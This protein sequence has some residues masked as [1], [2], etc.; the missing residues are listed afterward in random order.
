[1][2]K[3]LPDISVW[4]TWSTCSIALLPIV[5]NAINS[6][7]MMVWAALVVLSFFIRR[8]QME[9][10]ERRSAPRAFFLMGGNFVLLTISLLYSIDKKEG[11]DF[12][13]RELS[14][15]LFPLCFFIFTP[16]FKDSAC[17]LQKTLSF[18]WLATV[19]MTLWVFFQYW[20]LDLFSQFAR[21]DSFNL[22]LRQTAEDLTDKHADYLSIYLVFSQ[23]IAAIR[24]LK[25]TA[26]LKRIIYALSIPLQGLL[27]FLLAARSPIIALVIGTLIICFL[28]IGRLA[29][30]WSVL[31]G[32]TVCFLAIIRLT[33]SIW[34]R[35]EEVRNTPL[36]T[37]VGVYHNSTNIRV[38]I[39]KCT[40]EL[41]REH[42]LAGIGV[43]SD[44]QMLS[45]CYAQFPTD[46]Y[47]KTFY[48][49][50][51]QYLNFWLLGGILSLLLFLASIVWQYRL[52]I[53][54]KDYTFLFFLLLITICFLTE[55]ILSRQ[56][57]IVFYYFFS[58]LLLTTGIDRLRIHDRM[59]AASGLKV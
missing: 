1:M 25:K 4:L 52:S 36:N 27:L 41:I 8:R 35:I 2:T 53:H 12:L 39:Y 56:A 21:A 42:P 38:G 3:R 18:F 37:P 10:T 32:L 44:R 5:P 54:W 17:V 33:P 47:K 29:I 14:M 45:E 59:N 50:H 40:W 13:V 49:T 46:V 23:F 28:Q 51:D 20:R 57:G 30:R 31:L 34:S 15:I 58:C 24:V 26:P 11:G 9:I 55:N 16:V 43:G 6:I 22:I 7:C 48:N 19:L